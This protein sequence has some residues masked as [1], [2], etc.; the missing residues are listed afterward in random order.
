MK[1]INKLL[2]RFLISLLLFVPFAAFCSSKVSSSKITINDYR[3]TF[4]PLQDNHNQLNIAIRSYNR[5][6][7]HYFVVVDPYTLKTKVIKASDTKPYSASN[8]FKGTPYIKA[9]YRYTSPPY[10]LQNYGATSALYKTNGVFLTVDMCPS[11]KKFEKH[12]FK[13]L[14]YLYKKNQVAVPM[15]LCVSGLWMTKHKE[16]FAW[17]KK[18]YF[19]GKLDITWVNHSFSHP[20]IPGAPYENNFLLRNQENFEQEVLE[21]EKVLLE[22]H[23][24]P[25]VFFR[26]PGLISNEKLIKNLKKMSL[27]PIGSDA[28]LAKGESILPGSFIL[29]HGNGNEP[30]GIEIIMPLLSDFNLLPIQEA[31]IP[32]IKNNK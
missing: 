19:L 3:N 25:S 29:V 12:F 2:V 23:L 27:I 16:E 9:L 28:W 18:Q 30:K 4:M 32:L 31:F 21:T 17:L 7:I 8:A 14:L 26:F 24:V 10:K 22:N 11:T 20:Y 5:N 1:E 6:S 13:K 15:A